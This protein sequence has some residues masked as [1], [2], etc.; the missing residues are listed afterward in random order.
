M[1]DTTATTADLPAVAPHQ[2]AGLT[3]KDLEPSP[4]LGERPEFEWIPKDLLY[5][6]PQYQ[7]GTASRRSQALI[8]KLVEEFNWSK[9]Q[10]ITVTA[11]ETAYAVIDGQH[12]AIAA[13]M[14]PSVHE[15]PCWVVSAP[16][17]KAQA[18]VFL[19]VNED[20]N[21]IHP[22]QVYKAQLAAKHP[23]ALQIDAVCRAAGVT[24]AYFIPNGGSLPPRTTQAV[25][26]IRKL[27]VQHGEGPVRAVLRTLAEA[28]PD[29]PGQIRG[30]VITAIATLFV[31]H[32]DRIDE[33]RL[34]KV[35]ADNDCEDL[36]DAARSLKK[37][38]GGTTQAGLVEAL[39]RAY[40]K[41]LSGDRRLG[42]G[43]TV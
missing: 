40:D 30:Q 27:L 37:L 20:R 41:G 12:R 33:A 23:D 32:R 13:I 31:K 38:M 29:T 11:L 39:V 7:R 35:V 25:S 2:F 19:G 5:V 22:L 36:V 4:D 26:T 3:L 15:V 18:R 1:P 43:A 34:I 28:Y 14:H 24:L 16:D 21:Q 17:I 10:P 42:A 9:F 8:R 6:D